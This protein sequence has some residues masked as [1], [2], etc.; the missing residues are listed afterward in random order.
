MPRMIESDYIADVVLVHLQA[1]G[2]AR[3][4]FRETFRREWF[5]HRRWEMM[6]PN[7]PHSQA[8]VVRGLHYH[9]RQVD[10]WYVTAGKIRAALFDMRPGSRTY[11]AT[12]TLDMSAEADMGLFIPIGVAHGFAALTDATLIYVVDH[13]FD[14]SDE[15][16]VAWNDPTLAIDWGVAEPIVSPRDARY[17]PYAEIEAEFRPK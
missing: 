12:Q 10:Y 4:S 11:R 13:Y 3:G 8:G 15:F 6:Q 2:D 14:G 16:G 17:R 1:F 9:F 5:P 7:C